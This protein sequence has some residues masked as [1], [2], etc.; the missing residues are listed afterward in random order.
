MIALRLVELVGFE[1][2]N[3]GRTTGTD[4]ARQDAGLHALCA[5]FTMVNALLCFHLDHKNDVN[6]NL[7]GS[8]TYLVMQI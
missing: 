8:G 1:W 6:C 2:G 3:D 4:E 5:A 7:H